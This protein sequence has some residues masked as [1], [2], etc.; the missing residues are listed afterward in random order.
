MG[1][2]ERLHDKHFISREGVIEKYD[3]L[4]SIEKTFR[5]SKSDLKIRPIYHR[6]RKRIEAHICISFAACKVYKELERQLKEKKSSLSAQ[7]AIDILKTIYKA[8]IQT[9][10]S[11]NTYQRLIIKTQEQRDLVQLFKLEL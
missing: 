7:K 1:R 8:G 11:N 3:Q 9:P 4:W 2:T 10:Y 6:L 5:I